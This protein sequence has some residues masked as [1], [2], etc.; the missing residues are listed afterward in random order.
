MWNS[1]YTTLR[2]AEADAYPPRGIFCLADMT[3][4]NLCRCLDALGGLDG[5]SRPI[6][7]FAFRAGSEAHSTNRVF[8]VSCGSC[9][10][11]RPL[12]GLILGEIPPEK[13]PPRAMIIVNPAD[14]RCI[15]T[16]GLLDSWLTNCSLLAF[17]ASSRQGM[18]SINASEIATRAGRANR[19]KASSSGGPAGECGLSQTGTPDR[20]RDREATRIIVASR[21]P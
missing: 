1:W 12:D 11:D 14:R 10:G 8:F 9:V 7:R 2:F 19:R 18:R 13:T 4:C 16:L 21:E 15:R 17:N 3:A 20:N 6:Q 5:K